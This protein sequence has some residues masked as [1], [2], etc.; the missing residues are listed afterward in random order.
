[1]LDSSDQT[2]YVS[3]FS[4]EEFSKISLSKTVW[5]HLLEQSYHG[6]LDARLSGL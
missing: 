3:L 4:D 6:I 2:F 5:G 1:M